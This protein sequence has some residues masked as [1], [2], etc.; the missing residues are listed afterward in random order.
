MRGDGS[1]VMAV[2]LDRLRQFRDGLPDS[3][4]DGQSG[5]DVEPH[6]RSPVIVAGSECP[7]VE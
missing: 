3:K 6:G 5:Q 4:H 7:D 1:I 2:N